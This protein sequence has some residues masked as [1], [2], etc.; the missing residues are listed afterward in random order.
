MKFII[1]LI[2]S[3]VS[4]S[5]ASEY[6]IFSV[7]QQL[8]MGRPGQKLRKNYYVNMG[9]EQGLQAGSKLDVFRIISKYN[10]Y[11]DSKRVNYKVKI[12]TLS[13]LHSEKDS[14]IAQLDN[15][16]ADTN[17]PVLDIEHFMIG[18]HVSVSVD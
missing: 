2:L 13:V 17:D 16:R 6:I 7:S 15:I 14:A 12:G 3:V 10:P 8:N 5:S 1:L 11:D 18:D 4:Y 9:E